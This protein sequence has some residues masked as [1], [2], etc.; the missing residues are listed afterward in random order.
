MLISLLII[1]NN[2]NLYPQQY[3]VDET[4]SRLPGI[5]DKSYDAEFGDLNGDGYFDIAVASS[6]WNFTARSYYLFNNGSGVFPDENIYYFDYDSTLASMFG[7]GLG[8]IDRDGDLDVCLTNLE[9]DF[10]SHHYLFVNEGGGNYIDRS[11][12]QLP[13]H[14][15]TSGSEAHFIDIDCDFDL[16]LSIFEWNWGN[17]YL[18]ENQGFASGRFV[19]T[20]PFPSGNDDS[21]DAA[22]FDVDGDWDLDCIIV[23]G[24]GHP[25]RI[26]INY[27]GYFSE[28]SAERLPDVT[29]MDNDIEFFDL[30]GDGDLDVYIASGFTPAN[31]KI[32]INN[33]SGYFT[34][35]SVGRIPQYG[36]HSL[37]V[38]LGDIDNDNDFDVYVANSSVAGTHPSRIYVNDGTGHFTDETSLRY[39]SNDEESNDGALGDIDDDG[40]LDLY[41]VNQGYGSAEQN[42]L[43]INMSSPDSFP[44]MINRTL[45]HEDTADTAGPYIIM[46]EVWDN[47][48]RNIGELNVSLN[49]SIDNDPFDGISMY[50]CGGSIFRQGIGGYPPG[51]EVR[52]YIEAVDRMGNVSLDP[53]NAPD[54]VFSFEITGVGVKEDDTSPRIPTT[55]SLSQNYPNPFNPSTLI[56]YSIPENQEQHVSLSIYDLHGKVVKRLVDSIQSPGVHKIHW[57]GDNDHGVPVTSGIYFYRISS[58]EYHFT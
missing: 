43:L 28:E 22:W 31:D 10:E 57:D 39:P 23:N 42:R 14:S 36:D 48:S 11:N 51:T 1:S 18:W 52:Y 47:I 46:S 9:D 35:E 21:N 33:G 3:F 16:D 45:I 34:D 40:D 41:V 37:G 24:N 17:N 55:Y 8:D 58:G 5:I 12:E 2:L 32:W 20:V 38:C 19:A 29:T 4:S 7:I 54:S 6:G 30:D 25:D 27:G 50:Y 53:S 44:P 49:Y 15:V 26:M 56:Q 13:P